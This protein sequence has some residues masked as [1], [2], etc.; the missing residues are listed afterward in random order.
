M[1]TRTDSDRRELTWRTVFYGFLY[2]RRRD[3]RRTSEGEAIFT[4]YHHPWLFFLAI[5]I[6]VLSGMDAVFT[7]QLLDLGAIELNP[8]MNAVI[9]KGPVTF[10]LTKM[11]LTSFGILALVFLAR[12]RFM[13]RFRTGVILTLFFVFYAVLVCY[14]FVSLISIV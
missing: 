1:E 5:S 4:D 8:V 11:F 12:S 7:L 2:S 3:T 14:E 13:E 9:G 6:M 10:A